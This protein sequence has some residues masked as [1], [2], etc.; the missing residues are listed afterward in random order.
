VRER[1]RDTQRLCEIPNS[2]FISDVQPRKTFIVLRDSYTACE[3]REGRERRTSQ[4]EVFTG[5]CVDVGSHL[6]RQTTA[7]YNPTQQTAAM[8]HKGIMSVRAGST[9]IRTPVSKPKGNRDA[10]R[11]SVV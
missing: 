11:V 7:N 5:V 3:E 6:A 10:V 8:K 2:G 1:E 9:L 4:R